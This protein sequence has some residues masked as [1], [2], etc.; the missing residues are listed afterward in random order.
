MRR[1]GVAQ[2]QV[3][4]LLRRSLDQLRALTQD[5]ARR[6]DARSTH[7]YRSCEP[8][9]RPRWPS[10]RSQLL[11][12]LLPNVRLDL[13]NGPESVLL[14][15]EALVGVAET[16]GLDDGDLSDIRTAVTE[17]CNN[18]VLHAYSADGGP[19][20]VE[21]ELLGES[22][23]V[24][25]R[26][27]G[28]GM[29]R[30]GS[31]AEE[32]EEDGGIGLPVIRALTRSVEFAEP[33]G[34]GTEVSMLF[35]TPGVRALAQPPA[36]S[37]AQPPAAEIEGAAT[38]TV[39][40]APRELAQAVIPRMLCVLAARAR[41]STDRISESQL[42]AHALVAH[43]AGSLSGSHL[44]MAVNVEPREMELRL[45]PLIAGYAERLLV[46]SDVQG[47]GPV[48][49]KLAYSH[50]VSRVDSHDTLTLQLRDPR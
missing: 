14:V 11:M 12:A 4:R 24:T 33:P 17:A 36:D 23:H 44:S 19:L 32:V 22:T 29:G 40:V 31:C 6:P 30:D 49:E 28:E 1:V 37:L 39:S 21:I 34:G 16:V 2:M 5:S 35:A 43:A 25:V 3:S 13:S 42:L 27:H 7:R 15:R 26:D 9:E 46:D 8:V 10:S 38:A 18:V 41:F 50:G 20:E 48:L 45:G 47:L